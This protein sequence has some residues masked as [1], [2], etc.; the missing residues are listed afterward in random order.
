MFCA[1]LLATKPERTISKPA[2]DT[3]SL[4]VPVTDRVAALAHHVLHETQPRD[5]R[6]AHLL[7]Q[8]DTR[9]R[10][11]PRGD[12]DPDQASQGSSKMQR[13]EQSAIVFSLLLIVENL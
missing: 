1:P 2:N 10:E 6:Q 13:H 11:G 3:I 12:E 7:L 8:D 4:C 5:R 9:D